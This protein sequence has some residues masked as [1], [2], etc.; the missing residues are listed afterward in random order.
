MVYEHDKYDKSRYKTFYLKQKLFLIRY[1]LVC[2][3]FL[4][5]TLKTFM[6]HLMSYPSQ[7]HLQSYYIHQ[8]KQYMEIEKQYL[9]M[10]KTV[11]WEES[12]AE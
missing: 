1:F 6:R 5:S 8:G 3:G 12:Q 7:Q 2:E 11:I 4:N 9:P 10:T